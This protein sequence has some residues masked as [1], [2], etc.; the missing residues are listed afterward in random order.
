MN[1]NL[2]TGDMIFQ[3]IFEKPNH[4]FIDNVYDP[5]IRSETLL[6]ILNQNLIEKGEF[7]KQDKEGETYYIVHP[8]LKHISILSCQKK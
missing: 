1:K 2:D 7:M 4:E 8:I 6:E 3:K 5:H